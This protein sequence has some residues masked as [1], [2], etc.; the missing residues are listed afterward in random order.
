MPIASRRAGPARVGGEASTYAGKEA[1]EATA[2][3][4]KALDVISVFA[5]PAGP[6][7]QDKR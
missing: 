7:G 6:F 3:G 5:D 2:L 1:P 4:R